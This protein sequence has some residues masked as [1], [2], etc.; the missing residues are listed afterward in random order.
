MV[1]VDRRDGPESLLRGAAPGQLAEGGAA[2]VIGDDRPLGL[3]LAQCPRRALPGDVRGLLKGRLVAVR[4]HDKVTL[5]VLDVAIVVVRLPVSRDLNSGVR[6]QLV[7][8]DPGLQELHDDH[9]SILLA[10]NPGKLL[11]QPA[12]GAWAPRAARYLL[13]RTPASVRAAGLWCPMAKGD[14]VS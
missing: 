10:P 4:L 6:G 11:E 2:K 3:A 1:G 7:F 5:E 8:R 9:C 14:L 13:T 12:G